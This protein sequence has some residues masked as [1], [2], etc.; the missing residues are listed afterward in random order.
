MKKN[1]LIDGNNIANIAWFASQND[2]R[3]LSFIRI[4]FDLLS[5][6]L[7]RT[8]SDSEKYI[9]FDGSSA[10]RKK[11]FPE[12]KANRS[13]RDPETSLSFTREDCDVSLVGEQI[14]NQF[15][16]IERL[17]KL[18]NISMIRVPNEE[19]DDVIASFIKKNSD[20]L[21]M[22]FSTDRDYFLL[23]SGKTILFSHDGKVFEK[24]AIEAYYKKKFDIDILQENI[25]A[26]KALT[27]DTSDNVKG[28]FRLR[29]KMAALLSRHNSY[30]SMLSSSEFAFLSQSEKKKFIESEEIIRRNFIIL[31]FFDDVPYDDFIV[32]G[33][34]DK[35]SFVSFFNEN[36]LD[37]DFSSFFPDF[38]K[39]SFIPD[40]LSDI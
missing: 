39:N 13:A 7:G 33:T 40:F 22:V 36:K 16:L 5:S 18:T 8:Y 6:D 23:A 28:V 32:P 29:K 14:K 19:A 20:S 9:V 38:G 24:N 21:N 4:F 25:L 2:P 15:R 1:A 17:L 37:I 3:P 26:Y 10:R 30:E 12:Y 31:N 35:N 11:I 27:G 34:N